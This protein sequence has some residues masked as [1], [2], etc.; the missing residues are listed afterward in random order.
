MFVAIDKKSGKEVYAK[1]IVEES[2]NSGEYFCI[3]CGTEMV[4]KRAYKANKAS[5]EYLVRSHFYAKNGHNS[6]DCDNLEKREREEEKFY[7]N[8]YDNEWHKN[9]QSK[10]PEKCREYHIYDRAEYHIAD[11]FLEKSNIIIEFQ[12]SPIKE[13]DFR[14]RNDFYTRK[15]YKVIWLFDGDTSTYEQDHQMWLRNESEDVYIFKQEN[16]KIT[17]IDYENIFYLGHK[18]YCYRISPRNFIDACYDFSKYELNKGKWINLIKAKKCEIEKQQRAKAQERAEQEKQRAEAQERAKQERQR[19]EAQER[20]KQERQFAED[21]K[22]AEE[23]RQLE[24]EYIQEN[25]PERL[26]EFLQAFGFELSETA[27]LEFFRNNQIW[28]TDFNNG[29]GLKELRTQTGLYNGKAIPLNKFILIM[30][31]IAQTK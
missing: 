14:K 23:Q 16:Y 5:G 20:A 31:W 4:Y 2:Q 28:L 7:N 27:W 19:A 26:K 24:N 17:Q 8:D 29:Y 1:G 15:G 12:H 25:S 11:V 3:Y 22:R 21:Q 30:K 13:D 18:K 9:W 6:P 10:F